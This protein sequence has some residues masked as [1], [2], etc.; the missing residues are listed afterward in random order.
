MSHTKHNRNMKEKLLHTV[1]SIQDLDVAMGIS[2]IDREPLPPTPQM[3]RASLGATTVG[4]INGDAVSIGTV[5]HS[6]VQNGGTSLQNVLTSSSSHSPSNYSQGGSTGF[7]AATL[8][9]PSSSCN[10]GVVHEPGGVPEEQMTSSDA[11]DT[12]R[13]STL[14]GVSRLSDISGLTEISDPDSKRQS[15]RSS[16]SDV[17]KGDAG[18]GDVNI[19][20]Y[21]GD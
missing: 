16:V 2:G 15:V 20:F 9:A 21:Q 1:E 7:S 13:L 17:E 10:G 3:A 19:E 14:S 11:T 8:V 5:S 18:L 4:S 6:S 12:N